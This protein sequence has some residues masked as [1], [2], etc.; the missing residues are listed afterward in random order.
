MEAGI[1]A[2]PSE[3]RFLQ[4]L[5]GLLLARPAPT[6]AETTR[7]R[8]LLEQALRL[9]PDLAESHYQL[10]SLDLRAGALDSA[11]Q[12]LETAARLDPRDGRVHFALAKLYR[13]QNRTEEAQRETELFSRSALAAQNQ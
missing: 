7:A 12:H 10:G 8:M 13:K 9:R 3:P 11:A 4:A 5:G 1:A 6:A 2:H